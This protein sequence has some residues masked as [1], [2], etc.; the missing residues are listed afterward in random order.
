MQVEEIII[1]DS[2]PL[3]GLARINQLELLHQLAKR[4]VVPAAV[5]SESVTA[6]PDAPGANLL[7]ATS[8]IEIQPL[9]FPLPA[10]LLAEVDR[11]EAEAITLAQRFPEAVLLLDD[12]RARRVAGRHGLRLLGT[13]GLLVR[14][15]KAGILS[16]LRPAM[17]QLVAVGIHLNPEL[18]RAALAEVG[19]V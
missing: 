1:A 18:V 13:V 7:F 9:D 15:R 6:R 17:D 2:S 11:G 12:L 8:W 10:S 14:A 19:E 4:T 16:A 3:I 5:W